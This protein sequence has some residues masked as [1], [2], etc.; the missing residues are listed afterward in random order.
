MLLVVV[1]VVPMKWPLDNE[2]H[3]ESQRNEASK[4][5]PRDFLTILQYVAIDAVKGLP[6]VRFTH[7][8]VT[9]ES[10]HCPHAH[11]FG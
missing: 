1:V 2:S 5:A 9:S 4:K 10:F 3:S 6:G 8:M 7:L 11:A